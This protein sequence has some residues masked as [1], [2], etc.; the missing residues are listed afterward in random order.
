MIS[1]EF[2]KAF[3]VKF[4]DK[5][6]KEKFAWITC[7]GPAV[8]RI[9]AS[10][11]S[12]HGDNK[13]LKFP[14]KIAPIQ[15]MIIPIGED[16]LVQKQAQEIKKQ[17]QENNISVDI[18]N[19]DKRL[20]E[21]FYFW[22]MK[23]IPLRIELGKRELEKNEITIFRRDTDEKLTIKIKNIL[24]HI[25]KK[26][27]EIDKNLIKQADKLFN[28][29]IVSA[30]TKSEIKEIIEAG[31]IARCGFCSVDKEGTKCAEIIEKEISGE[32]RGTKL[33]EK[34]KDFTKCVA[35]DKKSKHTVYISKA[36]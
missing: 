36:Y 23:G 20:G 33:G 3:D 15:V 1:Q 5:N 6:E 25:Q 22:E 14:W 28:N 10:I 19:S 2:S 13:G 17:L 27:M 29:K 21:K 7:Y 9:F 24:E 8:S 31:K 34:N 26:S 4:T 18:D 30:K 12:V 32:V 16:K 35:C 11:V